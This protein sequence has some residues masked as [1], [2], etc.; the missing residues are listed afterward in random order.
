LICRIFREA[1]VVNSRERVIRA[2]NHQE[3]D[4]LPVDFGGT[5]CSGISASLIYK[6]RE[7]LGLKKLPVKTIETMEMLG[8]IDDELMKFIPT[9]IVPMPSRKNLYGID[10]ADWKPWEM[11]DGTP[12]LVPGGMNTAPDKNGSI[13]MYPQ[14]DTTVPPSAKMPKGGY[15]FDAVIRQE[16]IDDDN[17]R[18]EDNLEEFTLIPDDELRF[19]EEQAERL[20]STTELAIVGSVHGTGLGDIALVPGLDLKHPKGIRDIEEWYYSI[21]ARKDFLKELFDR[22]SDIALQNLELYRQAVGDRIS[23]LFLDGADF[24]T[25]NS[26]FCSVNT[27]REVYLPSYKKMTGWIHKN[28]PW[29]VLKHS[30]GAVE[31]L[32]ES[33]IEAGFDALNPVQSSAAGMEPKALKAKY[34]DRIVF[35]GGG[36]DT[37]QVLPFG[38]PEE[39]RSQVKEN[40][41][42]FQKNGGYI[43]NTIHNA[44][45]KVPVENFMAMLEVIGQ[46]R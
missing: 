8:E 31:P 22:Q 45:A 17:L 25:Q 26:M 20:Y 28:T 46:Y 33:L 39:V 21:A 16:P 7:R 38:T 5:S 18:V 35:W 4:K 32:I 3:T 13:L 27:F 41:E 44:Q 34:G 29:K 40:I 36:I 11:F 6:L 23:V 24:G 14:G 10:Y 2:L 15:Y 12:V 30:C 9:D 43:F 37:Q 19:I 42:I 1:I